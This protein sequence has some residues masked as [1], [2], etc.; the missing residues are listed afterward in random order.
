MERLLVVLLLID[1]DI[2]WLKKQDSTISASL[3]DVTLKDSYIYSKDLLC[4]SRDE[5]NIDLFS[6][7]F[8]LVLLIQGA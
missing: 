2:S 6:S 5:V 7:Y 8:Y 4:N 1:S 3:R